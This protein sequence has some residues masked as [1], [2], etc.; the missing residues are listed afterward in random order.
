MRVHEFEIITTDDLTDSTL[1][2]TQRQNAGIAPAA[3]Q[4]SLL[5]LW[6]W[7][8]DM[9]LANL[10]VKTSSL[11]VVSGTSPILTM[12][13]GYVLTHLRIKSPSVA[14]VKIGTTVGGSQIIEDEVLPADE[15]YSI[16]RNYA[17]NGTETLHLTGFPTGTT[18]KA[19]FMS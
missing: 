2:P 15:Y 8:W 4:F 14:T 18:V 5:S 3:R 13:D 6:F 10:W 12:N 7:I 9:L 16:A 1:I 19:Y 17:A 11:T